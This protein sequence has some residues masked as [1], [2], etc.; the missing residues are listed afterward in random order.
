VNGPLDFVAHPEIALLRVL[1]AGLL[2]GLIGMERER[3]AQESGE[4]MFAGVRTFPLFAI[5]GASL[6]I[7]SGSIGRNFSLPR[8]IRMS[9]ASMLG[10]PGMRLSSQPSSLVYW[11]AIWN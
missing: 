11:A 5:L 6:A 10:A 3:A 7:V 9:L 1:V 2:G 8:N 4:E